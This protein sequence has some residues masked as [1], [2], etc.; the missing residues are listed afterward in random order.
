M[1]LSRLARIRAGFTLAELLAVIVILGIL[2]ALASP[3]VYRTVTRS[4][5]N[6]A[7][8]VVA[9]D[10]EHAVSLAARQR[11]P[12]QLALESAATYTLRDRAASPADTLR[13]RRTLTTSGDQGVQSMTF[14]RTPVQIF[15]NGTTDGALTITVSGA[16]QTRTVT[17]SPAG[18]VRIN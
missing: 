15:P 13:L 6:Q 9:A 8:G 18:Q 7:A 17:M 10:L 11:K 1:N 16:G 2:A 5:V 12:V 3:K 14:S 4:K